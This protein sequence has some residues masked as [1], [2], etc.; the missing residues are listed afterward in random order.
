[1][2]YLILTLS[3]LYSFFSF[4]QNAS[5]HNGFTYC[6]IDSN[7]IIVE[8]FSANEK[9]LDSTFYKE[10]ISIRSFQNYLDFQKVKSTYELTVNLR[11]R[12]RY[13]IT[14]IRMNNSNDKV[15]IMS[16]IDFYQLKTKMKNSS[17]VVESLTYD[18]SE[19]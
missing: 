17:I 12:N 9:I 4:G 5:K 6:D 7:I 13:Q 2:K 10:Y 3:C 1:M 11:K 8:N 14:I 19:F 16:L 18:H 15:K